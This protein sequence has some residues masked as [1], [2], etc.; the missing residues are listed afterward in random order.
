[1]KNKPKTAA[2]SA[3]NIGVLG[4]RGG[5]TAG[6]VNFP[7]GKKMGFAGATKI[8]RPSPVHGQK[9]KVAMFHSKRGR[10]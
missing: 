4:A 9:A 7:A 2:F 10:V 6:K 5:K 1:M 8:V 3:K